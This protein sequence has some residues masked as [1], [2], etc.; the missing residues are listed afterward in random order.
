M[1]PSWYSIFAIVGTLGSIVLIIALVALAPKERKTTAPNLIYQD[2]FLEIYPDRLI[3]NGFY[4]G[5][6][7]R[8]TIS[9]MT[10]ET[11]KLTSPD[12][13]GQSWR[14]QGTGDF[15]YWLAH[16]RK[17]PWQTHLF[18]IHR[19]NSRWRLGFSA[20]DFQAAERHFKTLDLL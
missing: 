12:A 16:D 15:K 17:R 18:V 6:W 10:I 5:P 11:L 20:G 4:L 7:G 14:I 19:K 2:K 13:C 9:L 8:K 3:L 1:N